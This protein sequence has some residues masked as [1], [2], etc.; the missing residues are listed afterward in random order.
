MMKIISYQISGN[1]I[2]KRTAGLKSIKEATITMMML[3]L[4]E[5]V[6]LLKFTRIS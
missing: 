2:L 3:L 1:L 6:M 5:V 4:Q